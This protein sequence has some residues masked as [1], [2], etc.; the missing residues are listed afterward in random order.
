MKHEKIIEKLRDDEH[1]YGKFGK[2]YISNSDIKNL[3][4]EPQQ[5][6]AIQPDNDNFAKG[7]FFHQLILEPNKALEF[8]I[9]DIKGRNTKSYK[10]FLEENSLTFALTKTEADDI[11]DM[12]D[13]LLGKDKVLT[14]LITNFDAKYE[15]PM[16]GEI[17]GRPFK[18]KADI[19]SQG[20]CVDLK[21]TSDIF[22]FKRNAYTYGYD[23]QAF[24]YQ[25]LFEVGMTFIVVGK[26]RKYFGKSNIP[27]FDIGVF[28][29]TEEFVLQGKEKVE[30]AMQNYEKYFSKDA[31]EKIED[32]II[33]SPL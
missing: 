7:R 25:T 12:V 22:K 17:F 26:T 15:E 18:G 5:F 21:T 10:S 33:N 3:I 9:V 4:Y 1:Y 19:I 14:D 29:T 20:V 28:P 27:Y 2:Q 11:K 24:I 13:Y 6:G 8:P 16:I 32:L 30:L 23:T 31:T